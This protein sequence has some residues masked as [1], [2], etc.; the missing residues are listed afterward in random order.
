[1]DFPYIRIE[2]VEKYASGCKKY[3]LDYKHANNN[4]RSDCIKYCV[5]HLA[6]CKQRSEPPH[7]LL[8][9]EY[10]EKNIDQKPK[11]CNIRRTML[12]MSGKQC[13][14]KSD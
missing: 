2:H 1:M 10:F 13:N 11:K 12:K 14:K 4:I 3:D 8:R 5:E 9:R 7:S 6:R